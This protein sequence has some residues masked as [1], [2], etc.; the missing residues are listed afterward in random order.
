MRRPTTRA[1]HGRCG[2]GDVHSAGLVEVAPEGVQLAGLLD[3]A[4]IASNLASDI[5]APAW[6]GI[7]SP[8][9]A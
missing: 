9:S 8:A 1:L 6:R 2:H 3:V 4:C 5:A 7:E